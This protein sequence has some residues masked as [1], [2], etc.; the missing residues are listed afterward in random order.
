M[1]QSALQRFHGPGGV[2][3]NFKDWYEVANAVSRVSNVLLSKKKL[4][5]KWQTMKL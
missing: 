3:T 1:Y 4:K 2:A 5:K